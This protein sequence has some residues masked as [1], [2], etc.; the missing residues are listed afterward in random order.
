MN[1]F[2]IKRHVYLVLCIALLICAVQLYF[3]NIYPWIQITSIIVASI[4]TLAVSELNNKPS[5]QSRWF[6]LGISIF[7]FILAGFIILQKEWVLEYPHL[8]AYPILYAISTIPYSMFARR[9]NKYTHVFLCISIT[10]ALVL[11]MRLFF[12]SPYLDLFILIGLGVQ[13]I[14][15]T[16]LSLKKTV[17]V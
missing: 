5:D 3:Y 6:Y 12:H 16:I 8:L 17:N 4:I 14:W 9:K 7:Q 1:L 15:I 10:V 13:C 11:S 2:K